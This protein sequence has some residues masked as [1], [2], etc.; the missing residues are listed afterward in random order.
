MVAASLWD[1]TVSHE[2]SASDTAD[3]LV[4]PIP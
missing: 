2:V 3:T 1:E 4:T